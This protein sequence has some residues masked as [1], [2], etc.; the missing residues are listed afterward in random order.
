MHTGELRGKSVQRFADLS[1]S[2]DLGRG[3]AFNSVDQVKVFLAQSIPFFR[4]SY[5]GRRKRGSLRG[6]RS[7]AD[8]DGVRGDA[9]VDPSCQL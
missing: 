4:S 6:A 5:P 2:P 7:A 8:A 3:D 9:P 1:H